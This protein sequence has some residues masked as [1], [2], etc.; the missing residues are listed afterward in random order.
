MATERSRERPPPPPPQTP[1]DS[2]SPSSQ[3][4]VSHS[5]ACLRALTV[6]CLLSSLLSSPLPSPPPSILLARSQPFPHP[7]PHRFLDDCAVDVLHRHLYSPLL[8]LSL[9]CA[10]LT[11]ASLVYLNSI[12]IH[13][14]EYRICAPTF[15]QSSCVPLPLGIDRID[16]F[17]SPDPYVVLRNQRILLPASRLA[18]SSI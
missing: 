8:F 3:R 1:P 12:R 2:A 16:R 15:L 7:L 4:A 11:P 5:P 17:L 10:L 6:H 14:V 18:L 13:A 9:P